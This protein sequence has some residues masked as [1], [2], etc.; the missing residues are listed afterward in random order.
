MRNAESSRP[1]A[2]G[3]TSSGAG[4]RSTSKRSPCSCRPG[5]ATRPWSGFSKFLR[6]FVQILILGVGAWLV[7]QG[8]LTSGGMIAALDPA[9][10]RARAGRAG[11]SPP[12]RAWSRRAMP[13]T[14]CSALFARLPAEPA[15]MRLPAPLGRLSCEQVVVSRRLGRAEPVLRGVSFA[16][17]PGTGLGIVGPSAAGKSTLVQDPGRH[18]AADPRATCASTAPTCSPGTPTSSAGTSATCRRTSSCSPARS[19]RTSPG[20]RAIRIPTR[21][22]PR[23]GPPACTR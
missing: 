22:S 3:T 7:L 19:A 13:A 16:L 18:L 12:G 20:S 21:W 9:R 8:E 17:E 23:R 4:R 15:G 11:R 2:C 5:T 10:A 1:W 6:M 14:A